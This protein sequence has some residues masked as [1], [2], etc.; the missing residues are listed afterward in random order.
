MLVLGI[1][2]FIAQS[3]LAI[4]KFELVISQI[5]KNERDIESKLQSIGMANLLKLPVPDKSTDLPGTENGEPGT[6]KDPMDN[7]HWV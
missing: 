2:D 7:I 3:S 6:A 4:S 5:E 1:T